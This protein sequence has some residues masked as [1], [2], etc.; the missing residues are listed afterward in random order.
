MYLSSVQVWTW[1]LR[2]REKTSGSHEKAETQTGA[3]ADDISEPRVL[4]SL[5]AL[6]ECG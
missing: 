6:Q 1:L 4:F 5:T 3:H 2:H